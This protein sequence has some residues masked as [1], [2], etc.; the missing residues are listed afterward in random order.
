[1]DES[2]TGCWTNHHSLLQVKNQ[3]YLFY[4]HNDLSP[5]FD[6]NRSIRLDSLFFEP[7]GRIRQVVPTLRGVGLT[8]ARQKIQLDRYSRLSPRGAA[9]AFL[10]TAHSFQGWKTVLSG[11]QAWVQY[12]GVAFG[13]Q[14]L[15]RLTMRVAAPAG[16]TVQVRTDA[17]DGPVL[18]QVSVPKAAGWREVQVPLAAFKPGTHHLVVASQTAAPVEI[19]WMRFE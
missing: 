13:K 2:P 19:D 12:N 3:W 1:M 16:A 9:I 10:D 14:P 5:R 18:A 15:R 8:D 4:H 6:K 11:P 17:A 7:D